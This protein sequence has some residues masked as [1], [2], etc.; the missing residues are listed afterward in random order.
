M[1]PNLF[2]IAEKDSLDSK[3]LVS[4]HTVDDCLLIVYRLRGQ[5]RVIINSDE[6]WMRCEQNAGRAKLLKQARNNN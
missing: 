1:R 5:G 6:L 4:N 3:S 2:V